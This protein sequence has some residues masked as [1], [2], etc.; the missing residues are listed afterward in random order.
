MQRWE[1]EGRGGAWRLGR[2]PPPGG[3]DE[4][5]EAA[6]QKSVAARPRQASGGGCGVMEKTLT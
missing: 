4:P 5:P 2:E 1:V 3:K 6:V